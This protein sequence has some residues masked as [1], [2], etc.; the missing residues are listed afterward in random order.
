M[1]KELKNKYFKKYLEN[2]WDLKQKIKEFEKKSKT[3]DFDFLKISSWVFSS[4]IE[5]NS[6]DLNS[7]MNL[8]L[9]KKQTKEKKEIDDLIKA[10]DFAWKNIL[11]QENLLEV[12][13]IATKTILIKANRWVYRNDKVWVFWKQGLVYLAVEP[14]F[15][16]KYMDELF[17]E[18]NDLLKQDL[19]L[20]EVFFYASLIHLR[21]AHI[22]PF[23][24]WNWRIARILEKWFLVQKL[25]ENFWKLSSEE[26]YYKNRE[27]YYEYINLWVNFYELD[28]SKSLNFLGLLVESLEN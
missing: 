1:L 27:K 18:I 28:Y 15:V 14:E 9:N 3:L 12:H 16:W 8:E 13:K 25:G 17:D 5:G 21:F 6:L 2:I 22:H 4:K 10:Y 19:S 26:F 23:M 24:D 20:E 11:N 7:F